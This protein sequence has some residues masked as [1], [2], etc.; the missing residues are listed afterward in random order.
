ML[1]CLT[2]MLT[3][4]YKNVSVRRQR[5][6]ILREYYDED[7]FGV[8]CLLPQDIMRR[9]KL[10]LSAVSSLLH[11]SAYGQTS[12]RH[13]LAGKQSPHHCSRL[14]PA[15]RPTSPEN[16]LATIKP[17]ICQSTLCNPSLPPAGRPRG[18]SKKFKAR[19]VS[20]GDCN[21]VRSPC[22]N[23]LIGAKRKLI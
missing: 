17:G 3:V 20:S 6:R 11:M 16:A 21:V 8:L 7:M 12:N 15:G 4:L 9:V 14:A 1:F 13:N 23:T 19:C 10:S 18:L 22:H 2:L 5:F